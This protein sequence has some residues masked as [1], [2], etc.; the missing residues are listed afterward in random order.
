MFHTKLQ[1]R[2]EGK[3]E[4]GMWICI[5]NYCTYFSTD[6]S[7]WYMK[8]TRV[9]TPTNTIWAITNL[10]ELGYSREE[11]P[12]NQIKCTPNKTLLNL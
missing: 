5:K 11:N 10:R 4:T 2:L 3:K 6:W 7:D 8:L 1:C 12:R 9:P